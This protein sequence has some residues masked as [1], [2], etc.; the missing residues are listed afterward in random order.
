MQN[1]PPQG[2]YPAPAPQNNGGGKDT[3][4]IVGIIIAIVLVIAI[5]AGAAL[6]VHFISKGGIGNK[7]K[8][9]TETTVTS[10]V[11]EEE[12]E[13][14]TEP[15]NPKEETSEPKETTTK[16]ETPTKDTGILKKA[17][18]YNEDAEEYEGHAYAIFN[19]K[20]NELKDYKDCEK[21][22]EEMGGH[23]AVINS[24]EENDFIYDYIGRKGYTL[25]M[26]GYSDEKGEGK[27]KWVNGSKSKYT[28][29]AEGQPNNGA[30]NRSGI[31]ENYAEFSKH[32]ANGQWN[33]TEFGSNTYNFICEWE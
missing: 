4:K 30:N 33:D 20:D 17:K 24:Q 9:T 10:T 8:T 19:Y 12:E 3:G 29:W 11:R 32:P 28:N 16:P 26:F 5:A 27:W 13:S 2:Y 18:K 25:V 23:L 22:C 15:E 1:Q 21:F 31:S 7:D 14:T 6:L